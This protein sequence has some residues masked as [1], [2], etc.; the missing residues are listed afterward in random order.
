MRSSVDRSTRE[1]SDDADDGEDEERGDPDALGPLDDVD[2]RRVDED[3]R[4][5]QEIRQP[6]AAGPVDDQR[7]RDRR[8]R[9]QHED[10]GGV[11]AALRIDVGLEEDRHDE[12]D[13]G[14]DQHERPHRLR[15]LRRHAVARQVAR[16]EVEQA[17]HRRRAGE[18]QDGDRAEVVE[19]AEHLAEVL[20]RQVGE[21]APVGRPAAARS[22][23][24][25]IRS[26]GDDAAAHEQ[27]AHD[28]RRRQ[29]QPL[30]PA[31]AAVRRRLGVAG[32]ALHERHHRD[33]GLEA[34]QAQRELREQD[35]RHAHHRRQA[36][37]LLE[38][39]VTPR[40]AAPRGDAT[41][42]RAP[43]PMTTTFS[44]R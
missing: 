38:E 30:R 26:V 29:Q 11:G 4:D 34:G 24:A 44:A 40:R 14:E 32:V 43:T 2:D 23:P 25:G 15:P 42:W 16:H 1:N 7:D 28:E 9:H 10:A 5:H 21:R 37:V 3:E 13:A 31:D 41:M 17:G 27:H 36:A 6:A 12:R 35:Q 19:R 33:A 20:V 8:R 18:P 22:A 39:R